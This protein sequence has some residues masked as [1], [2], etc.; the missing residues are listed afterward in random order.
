MGLEI[1]VVRTPS[2]MD[3]EG[4]YAVKDAV[5]NGYCWYLGDDKEKRA[6]RWKELKE[7]CQSLTRDSIMANTSGPE[8]L[9]KCLNYMAEV[10]F[11]TY[12]AWVVSAIHERQDGDTHLYFDYDKLPGRGI[13][14]S[15]SRNL[16][17]LFKSCKLEGKTL[18]PCGDFICELD[19]KKVCEMA[20]KWRR[21][22]IK[23]WVAKWIGYFSP[24]T[25]FRIL[26]DCLRELGVDDVFVDFQD[27]SHYMECL[28][29]VVKETK[30]HADRL[31][32]VASY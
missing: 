19:P 27:F 16:H 17:S 25:G 12:L 28:N 2:C 5:E 6:E 11:S 23:A 18:K 31:W 30:G 22:A 13:F 8:D 4:L 15:C 10:D 3:L 29:A 20:A 21:K 32:L 9:V 24:E 1:S 7:K 14:D 26:Q